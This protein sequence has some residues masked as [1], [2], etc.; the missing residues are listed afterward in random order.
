[1]HKVYDVELMWPLHLL[2]ARALL[3]F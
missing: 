1:M 2:C 3:D